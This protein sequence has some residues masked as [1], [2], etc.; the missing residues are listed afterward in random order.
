MKI[1]MIK[2]ILK[3]KK[4]LLVFKLIKIYIG[5][6]LGNK[7]LFRIVEIA[8]TYKCNLKCK[9]CSAYTLK[10]D[11][12]NLTLEDYR[13]LGIE[14]KK[15]NVPCVSFTGGEPLVDKRIEEI[16]NCFNPKETIIAIMTNGVLLTREK[17]INF[18]S[19]GV[20]AVYIS[21]DSIN[22]KV[23]DSFRNSKGAFG[24]SLNAI[25]VANEIG[26]EAV[27]IYTLSHT[28]INNFLKIVD[29]AKKLNVKLH[30][31]LAS[32]SGKW[33]NN[34]SYK[35]YALTKKDISFLEELRKEYSFIRRDLDGSYTKLGCPAGTERFCLTPSGEVMPCTK[36][37]VSFGNVKKDS[38]LTIRRRMDKYKILTDSPPICIC[39]ESKDFIKNHM[40]RCF[41]M[42]KTLLT[43]EEFFG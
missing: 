24:K 2:T 29:F 10:N 33:A 41:N 20:D 17:L 32:P 11:Q 39:A 34:E 26:L 27:I 7:P 31:S 25:K 4:P 19:I 8:T 43:E 21:I 40:D 42:K 3:T 22:Y 9:H 36:I 18:K 5:M 12:Q 30:I 37:H 16:I 23:H 1:T 14:C 13:K 38:I 35:K 28:N 15:H 6:C